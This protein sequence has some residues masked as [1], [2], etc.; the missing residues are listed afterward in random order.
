[1]EPRKKRELVTTTYSFPG[2]SKSVSLTQALRQRNKRTQAVPEP[3]AHICPC[4]CSFSAQSKRKEKWSRRCP[5]A[6]QDGIKG[7]TGNLFIFFHRTSNTFSLTFKTIV[8]SWN[9]KSLIMS[10]F[11]M[12]ALSKSTCF[13]GTLV[14]N[15]HCIYCLQSIWKY[16]MSSQ[17]SSCNSQGPTRKPFYFF[18]FKENPYLEVVTRVIEELEAKQEIVKP[19]RD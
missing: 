17:P 18:F 11:E 6:L 3:F 13:Q 15:V 19:S 4:P 16:L 7:N 12:F 5:R 1:M 8:H 10:D 14:A 9:G 2:T